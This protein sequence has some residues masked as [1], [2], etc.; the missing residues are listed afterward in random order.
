MN[1]RAFAQMIR[2]RDE[3]LLSMDAARIRA[4]FRKYNNTPM[5]SDPEIFWIAVHKARTAL[6]SLPMEARSESK[7]WLIA[8]NAEPL[9][10]GEVPV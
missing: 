2:E 4:Y 3:A 8:H 7:R 5:P 6:R 10:D 9:D 1:D